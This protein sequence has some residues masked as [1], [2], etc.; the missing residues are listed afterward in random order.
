MDGGGGEG[1]GEEGWQHPWGEVDKDNDNNDNNDDD[2]DNEDGP[3]PRTRC[4]RPL[5]DIRMDDS[6]IRGLLEAHHK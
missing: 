6:M 5:A 4:C 2:D 1:G 3:S